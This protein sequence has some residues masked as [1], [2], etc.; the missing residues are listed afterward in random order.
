MKRSENAV[1][2]WSMRNISLLSIASA[3]TWVTAVAVAIRKGCP[4]NPPSPIKSPSPK[5]PTTASLPVLETT[6][7]FTPP[8]RMYM[9]LLQG[10]PWEKSVSFFANSDTVL[11]T[12]VEFRK[13]SVLNGFGFFFPLAGLPVFIWLSSI[14]FVP[15]DSLDLCCMT[16]CHAAW[17]IWSPLERSRAWDARRKHERNALDFH[18][19]RSSASFLPSRCLAADRKG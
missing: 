7:I 12:P 4:A 15:C 3:V 14:Q 2:A 8:F 1:S 5:I 11:A 18:G 9:M 10:S 6:E 17:K 13:V 19:V 16:G